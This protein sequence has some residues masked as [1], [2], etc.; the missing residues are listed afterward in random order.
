LDY[1]YCDRCAM[2]SALG[3][4]RPEIESPPTEAESRSAAGLSAAGRQRLEEAFNDNH[5][6]VWRLLR[7][8]GLNSERAADMTQQA[9]LIAAERLDAIK[10]GSERA[11][12]FG[13]ALRLARTASRTDRR[14]VLGDDLDLRAD[15]GSGTEEQADHHRAIELLDRVLATMPEELVTVFV[16]FELEGLT[17]PEVAQLV[18]IPVGT[19][20]SRLRRSRDVFRTAVA[21]IQRGLLRGVA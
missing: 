4:R 16:L 2:V 18:G 3:W 11:F 13:T 12:L 5:E 19:A 20:A 21:K 10:L 17:A 6:F 8:L 14:W 15:F 7:R 1:D 9:F